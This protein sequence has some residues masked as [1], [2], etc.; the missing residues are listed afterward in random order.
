[1]KS[2]FARKDELYSTS[3]KYLKQTNS[4]S[5][6]LHTFGAVISLLWDVLV[7]YIFMWLYLFVCTNRLFSCDIA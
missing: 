5:H 1:M 4:T 3:K 7:I 6:G 2:Y